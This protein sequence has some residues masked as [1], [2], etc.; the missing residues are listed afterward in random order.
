MSHEK[1]SSQEFVIK[2]PIP[3]NENYIALTSPTPTL[4]PDERGR[5]TKHGE[6]PPRLTMAQAQVSQ[7]VEAYD[8][9]PN[10]AKQILAGEKIAEGLSSINDR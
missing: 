1:D 10:H 8:I 4:E 6:L 5:L 7:L 9:E 2:N 3:L